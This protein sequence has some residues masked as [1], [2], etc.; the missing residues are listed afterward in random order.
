MNSG[1]PERW[2]VSVGAEHFPI[3][4]IVFVAKK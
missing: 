4:M 1:D 2:A 3:A